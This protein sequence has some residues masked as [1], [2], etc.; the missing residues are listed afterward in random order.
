MFFL[1]FIMMNAWMTRAQRSRLLPD[2]VTLQYA[3]SIGFVS[4]GAGYQLTDR[5]LLSFHYGY[6]PEDKGGELNIV[7]AKLVFKTWTIRMSE[8]ISFDP[9]QAGLMMSY[10][11]GSE[12]RSRWPSHRYPDG[13]YWWKS[14]LHAHLVTQTSL[15]VQIRNGHVRS[16][17]G[18]V[19]FNTNELYLISYMKNFHSLSF[20]DIIKVGYGIRANF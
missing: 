12:F 5:S 15:T 20:T 16:L 10:H 8:G 9:L 19:D 11:F 17:T 3:G 7:A 14:S 2:F 18:F 13:Y 4:G 1:L 6:V